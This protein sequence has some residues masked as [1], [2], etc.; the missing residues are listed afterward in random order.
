MEFSRQPRIEPEYPKGELE[1]ESPPT[2]GEKPEI[3]W[4]QTFI[5]PIIMLVVTVVVFM[6]M[7]SGGMMRSPLFLVMSVT[8]TGLMLIGSV[9]MLNKQLTKHS[10]DKK[11]RHKAYKG[12][13]AEK[14]A[15]LKNA[16]IQQA[17][18][19]LQINPSPAEYV[20]RMNTV[21]TGTCPTDPRLW[22]RTPGFND[23]LSFRLG[24]GTA[25]AALNVPK[26]RPS[27]IL[28]TDPL[29]DEPRKLALKHEK[30]RDVPVCVDLRSAQICGI[31]GS[32]GKT[33]AV[34]NN[35]LIQIAAN[36]GYDNVRVFILAD[37]ET[38]KTWEW[39]RFL[40]HLW[41]DSF[42]A[43]R[44]VCSKDT[45]KLVLDE[46]YSDLKERDKKGDDIVFSQYYVFIIASPEIIEDS[47]IRKHIYEP[48]ARIGVTSI[49]LAEHSALLPTHCGAIVTLKEK[50]G[51][52][53]DR[54]KNEKNIFVP[55]ATKYDNLEMAAR[56]ISP[57]RIK[58]LSTSSS[59]SKSITLCQILDKTD[60]SEIDVVTNWQTR[61]TYN[62]MD[63]PYGVRAGGEPVS[64][65]LHETGHGPHGLVAGTTG[66]GKS[67]LLQSIIIALSINF[68]PHDVVFVLIDYKGGGMADVFKGMPHLAGVIT[69][70]GGG[71]T[72][73]ALLSIK[74]EILR[75][76]SVFA[77]FGVNNIDKYQRLYYRSDRPQGIKPVPH[78]VMIA[79]EF[80]E[81]QQDQ[82]DFMK[83]L[84]SAARVGRSLG[85]HLILATQKPDGVVDDQ[86]WSNSKFKICLKVQT[87]SDSNGVLK[88]PDAAFIREPG[89]AYMQVGNDEI[90]ELL[91]SVYSGADYMPDAADA[92]E[93]ASREKKIYRLSADGR[94]AQIYPKSGAERSNDENRNPSQL[95]TMVRHITN[96]SVAAGIIPLDGPWTEPLEE[97]VYYNE[98]PEGWRVKTSSVLSA[99]GGIVD[100]PRKQCKFALEFDFSN[101]GGLLVYGASGAG[102]TT[103][104]KTLCLSMAERYS[105]DEV[106]IYILDMGGTAMK[107]FN[108]L[109]HCGG[110]M[111]IDQE[112][113]IRQFS[114]FLFRIVESRKAAFEKENVEDFVEYRRND[115]SMP[116]VVVMID[117]YAALSEM[118]DDIDE[119]LTLLARDAFRYG[120]YIIL[121]GMT[122]RDIRFKLSNCFKMAL[123]F[124]L[125][126]KSY[127]EIVGRT[128]GMEPE[129]FCGRGLVKLEKPLE[130]QAAIPEYRNGTEIVQ[131]RAIVEKIASVETRRATPIPVMPEKISIN[132][133]NADADK[134]MIGLNDSDLTPVTLNLAEHTS[135]VITGGPG[136]GKSTIAAAW[137]NTLKDVE[138]YI[139]DSNG[140]GFMNVLDNKNTTDLLSVDMDNFIVEFE[141][142]LDARRSELID[143]RKSGGDVNDVVA[144][145]KHVVFAFDKFS[146]ASDSD[147]CYDLMKLL[148]RIIKKEHG[149]KVTVLAVDTLDDLNGDY[150]DIG[151]AIKNEQTALLLGSVKEQSMF[152][153]GLPY[154][155]PEKSFTFGDGYVIKKSRF[156]GIRA[157]I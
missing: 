24:I 12:Y 48:N 97:I 76:Q 126:D 141:E 67:E 71:Q 129:S 91:Q 109:P 9:I 49:F 44:V 116:A 41:N 137:I 58:S 32:K 132:K 143:A 15:E 52:V 19:M 124:E 26:V 148:Y 53:V 90:Y 8:M 130:F 13:L 153:V 152:N 74:S 105:P 110:V 6:M 23:F 140:A 73:R 54:K 154:G 75:R 29:A 119:Q 56:R 83:Q 125:I 72:T 147:E 17:K 47:P 55:D 134:F 20:V 145:W 95:E 63:V 85:I 66:S 42:T 80:A 60:L 18:A 101:D 100:D 123:T 3:Q 113:D 93:K 111:T 34:V 81:L 115:L 65:D 117:G 135:F 27:G 96:R 84:V 28:E 25:K 38:Y 70:L 22:E 69:N 88:K 92:A 136:C 121:T 7:Q 5:S 45:A 86:I 142:K 43:R 94:Q 36:H 46:V 2:L 31:I 127:S 82:P 107:V 118:Y 51:D 112:R 144:L 59:L 149:M 151:R 37:D 106:H 50:T 1:I 40:P 89:R 57:L 155:T 104:L 131:T 4:F 98:L 68:H 21:P 62:G 87:E 156:F 138:F 61:R 108:T 139:V 114:Q 128:E 102:K 157:A 146:E 16:A 30:V 122:T 120:I 33:G 103:L 39:F 11:R 35:I 78:L 99:I 10:R 64:L 77:E 150:S 14:E 79:D 133:L